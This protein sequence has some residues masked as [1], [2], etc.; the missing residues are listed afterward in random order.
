MLTL[1]VDTAESIGGVALYE[2]DVLGEEQRMDAPLKHAEC[3]IP[4]IDAVLEA[5][6][7]ALSEVDRIAVNLGPGSFTGLRIG[8]ATALGLSQ[9]LDRT[10][11]GVD[12]SLAYRQRASSHRRVCV[13]IQS[14]RDL[15][16]VRWFSGPKP[17]GPIRLQKES[18]LIDQLK[19]E[20]RTLTLVGSA[21]EALAAQIAD[22]PW[23][24]LGSE[25]A[26]RPSAL[27]IAEIGAT[28]GSEDR[29][30]RLEPIY[31]EP[32]LA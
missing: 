5:A 15:I 14:R 31:V 18:E 9:A 12:G 13:A 21:A 32:V 7:R 17:R 22:H 4:S 24:E 3:L 10:L 16:Y 11:V 26:L 1:G 25:D 28:L 30:V 20:E 19:S 23:I 29:S 2:E 6:N 27:S 8:L